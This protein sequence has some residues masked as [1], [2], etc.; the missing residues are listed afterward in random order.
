MALISTDVYSVLLP[1]QSKA[2]IPLQKEEDPETQ[3]TVLTNY[4]FPQQPRTEECEYINSL[5]GCETTVPN[6][7]QEIVDVIQITWNSGG[8]HQVVPRL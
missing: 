1:F 2:L 4:M 3:K 6:S 8:S 5:H 7:K